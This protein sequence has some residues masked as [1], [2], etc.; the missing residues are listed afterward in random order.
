MG[1]GKLAGFYKE[2]DKVPL[3]RRVKLEMKAFAGGY[4][5]GYLAARGF[6]DIVD[7]SVQPGV[8]KIYKEALRAMGPG[9]RKAYKFEDEK[10]CSV[11]ISFSKNG[12][13]K[14]KLSS[15]DVY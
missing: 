6:L 7:E 14:V 15:H 11:R 4:V 12:K 8:T 5:V 2:R 9:W 10:V 3:S 1:G 13:S